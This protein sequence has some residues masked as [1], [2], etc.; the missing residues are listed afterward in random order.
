MRLLLAI[1][2]CGT[3]L[4]QGPARTASLQK[5]ILSSFGPAWIEGKK[6]PAASIPKK[7]TAVPASLW[8]P[9]CFFYESAADISSTNTKLRTLVAAYASCGISLEVHAYELKAGYPMDPEA[10]AQAASRACPIPAGA[11]ASIQIEGA[12]GLAGLMCQDSSATKCSTLCSERSI[13]FL[14]AGANAKVV[15]QESMRANCCGPLCVSEGEG[16]GASAGVGMELSA[17]PPS[18]DFGD[19]R[20]GDMTITPGGCEALRAGANPNTEHRWV[21]SGETQY[22]TRAGNPALR[23]DPA[24][25]PE[26]KRVVAES[27][28]TKKLLSSATSSPSEAEPEPDP[29]ILKRIGLGIFSSKPIPTGTEI[30]PLIEEV[31]RN[32]GK[33]L[34]AL[35]QSNIGVINP[36]ESSEITPTAPE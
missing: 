25:A 4:G 31:K 7:G 34:R 24:P 35:S 16:A 13:S 32:R 6:N 5:R 10:V 17:P 21:L 33:G 22:Y 28:L 11:R 19:S 26:K 15:L 20:I 29:G 1:L 12:A 23:Y 36:Y 3:A 18:G 30:Q 14:P 8:L 9:M 27:P 2:L